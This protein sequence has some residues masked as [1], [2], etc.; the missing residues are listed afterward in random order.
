MPFGSRPGCQRWPIFDFEPQHGRGG[1]HQFQRSHIDRGPR[2]T[3]RRS[4]LHGAGEWLSVHSSRELY[5]HQVKVETQEVIDNPE[6]E[7]DELAL[8]YQARAYRRAM[9]RNWLLT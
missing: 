5:E 7:L 3:S 2:R 1:R 6:E 9:P 8:I 4:A